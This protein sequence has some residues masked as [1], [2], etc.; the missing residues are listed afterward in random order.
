[1]VPSGRQGL[2]EDALGEPSADR[3]LG[4]RAARGFGWSLSRS[5][6]IRGLSFVSF[7]VLAR[8]LSPA[9][10]GVAALA[11]VFVGLLFL[12]TS[13]GLAQ[14]LV[15]RPTIDEVDLDSAFWMSTG[16]GAA[17]MVTLIIGAWP[18]AAAVGEPTLGPVLQAMSVCLLFAG[19]AS[20][21]QALLQR[22]LAFDVLAKNGMASNVVATA[23]GVT[24]ALL[25]FGVWSLVVQSIIA[26]GGASLGMIIAARFRPSRRASWARARSLLSFSAHVLGVQLTNFFNNRTDDF[27]IGT[28]LGATSLGIYT[29]AYSMLMVMNDVLMR[30]VQ[31]VIFPV[32]SRLQKDVARLRQAYLT[33][34]RTALFGTAPMFL[35]VAAAAPE[36]VP[37]LFGSKWHSSVPVMQILCVY[38]PLNCLMQFNAALLTSIGRP[39]TVFRIA[40]A[41]TALQVAFFAVAVN[42]GIEAVAASYVARA[43]LIAPVG[44]VIASRALGDALRPILAGVVPVAIACAVMV[45]AVEAVRAA[46]DHAVPDLVA[47]VAYGAVAL[48]AYLLT[49]R[50]IAADQLAQAVR[51]ARAAAPGRLRLG[52]LSRA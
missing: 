31:N 17:L 29:V 34:V 12:F 35:F 19:V 48:P 7:A 8:L 39:R 18:L 44:L 32:F 42:F 40:I 15:Q 36:L 10:Y 11:N 25:G 41:G 9:D 5:L 20:A 43:Y 47:V 50:L 2:G 26:N 3:P 37:G 45:L 46:L 27:L 49:M 30:P 33:A 22:R 4:K 21:S 51:Y 28:V 38:A 14:A 1:M 23:V 13:A 52:W 24:F 6:V 16:L